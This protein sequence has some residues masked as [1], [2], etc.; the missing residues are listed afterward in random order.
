MIS[1]KPPLIKLCLWVNVLKSVWPNILGL[2]EKLKLDTLYW[3]A[4][5]I[6]VPAVNVSLSGVILIWKL[7]IKGGEVSAL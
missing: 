2:G 3:K 7:M 4:L 5:F 6:R 1:Q